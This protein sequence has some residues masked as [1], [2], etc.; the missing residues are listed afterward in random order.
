MQREFIDAGVQYLSLVKSRII[1]AVIV[2]S[3]RLLYSTATPEIGFGL[4]TA[5]S[6]YFS[7]RTDLELKER[8]IPQSIR[9]EF[10]PIVFDAVLTEMEFA[11]DKFNLARM[12]IVSQMDLM[13]EVLLHSGKDDARIIAQTLFVFMT[14]KKQRN[15][16]GKIADKE[17]FERGVDALLT[18]YRRYLIYL[19]TMADIYK[20]NAK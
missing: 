10:C 14:N 9:D 7:V 19:D 2:D 15:D 12:I 16:W 13:S 8:E 4:L 20:Q 18:E 5:L 1:G 3:E 11:G 17:N 6:T